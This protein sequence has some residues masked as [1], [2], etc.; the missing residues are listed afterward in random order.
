MTREQFEQIKA[1]L[2]ATQGFEN[3]AEDEQEDK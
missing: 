2:D 3:L 1:S